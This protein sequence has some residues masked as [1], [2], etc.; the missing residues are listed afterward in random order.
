MK[1]RDL[2]GER[3]GRLV[4]LKE[5]PKRPGDKRFRWACQCDCGNIC[6]AQ[7]DV[8]FGGKKSCG[9]LKAA[10][11]KEAEAKRAAGPVEDWGKE[12]RSIPCPFPANAC[13]ASRYG[14]C[15][16]DCEEYDTCPEVCHNTPAKCGKLYR[17][18]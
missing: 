16:W 9:C 6:E 15:C 1:K 3:F 10:R 13:R 14:R 11:A 12:K 17:G 18:D 7:S 8:L 4:V 5:V 2:T